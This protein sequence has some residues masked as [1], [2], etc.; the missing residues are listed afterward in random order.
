[1]AYPQS[2]LEEI[3]ESE[4]SMFLDG[5]ARYGRHFKHARAVTMYLSLCV[6]SVDHDRSDT[7]GRLFSL[8]KKQHMLAFLSALRLHKVQAM[9]NLRQ[10][11]EAGA[12]AAY[13]IANPNIR[14]FA[15]IDA[16]GIMDPSQ[17]LA[18]KRYRWLR[19]NYPEASKRIED[20]KK[21]I[22]DQNAHANIV[23]A[24]ATFRVG[25]TKDI[26]DLPFFDVEDEY[27]VKADL[28]RIG[29]A[30]ITLMDL[31][32]GVTESV[33]RATGQSV[34]EFR[35]DFPN[36]IEGLVAESNALQR[37]IIGSDRYKAAM[38][39]EQQRTKAKAK[40]DAEVRSKTP[41]PPT[42]ARR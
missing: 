13:A 33:A 5:E 37:E 36:T 12:G 24:D 39:K 18:G 19:E 9:L 7:F 34:L 10:V 15:D 6:V 31:F 3:V 38:R 40:L 26:V 41:L 14:D 20:I 22:N 8:M 32:Y 25:H 16:F 17:K 27:F 28:W 29:S 35:P 2:T 11:L 1:M 23:S 21:E 30:A 42:S 4:R